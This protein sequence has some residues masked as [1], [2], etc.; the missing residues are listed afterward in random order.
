MW[1]FIDYLQPEI[2]EQYSLGGVLDMSSFSTDPGFFS[3]NA[4][5]FCSGGLTGLSGA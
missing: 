5:L 3:M 2:T 4:G 1:I